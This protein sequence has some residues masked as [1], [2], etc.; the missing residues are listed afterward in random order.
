MNFTSKLAIL[1]GSF[2]PPTNGHLHLISEA[3]RV[4]V[5]SV[6]VIPSFSNPWKKNQT[7]FSDRYRMTKLL[8]NLYPP[9]KVKVSEIERVMAYDGEIKRNYIPTH[10]LL[11]KLGKDILIITTNETYQ[12]IPKWKEGEKILRE[13]EFLIFS[14]SHL[15]ETIERSY[16]IPDLNI[17]STLVRECIQSGF[18]CP[19]YLPG[20]VY[21]YIKQ[22]KLYEK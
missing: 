3:L 18:S 17:S 13:Y 11:E 14:T 12:E 9:G 22:N 20:E 7:P 21:Q 19:E 2:D 16:I 8:E 10:F 6:M 15:G 4:G 5:S 1:L